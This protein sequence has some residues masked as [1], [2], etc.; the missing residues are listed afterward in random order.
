MA[1]GQINMLAL[2][3]TQRYDVRLTGFGL[4]IP[5]LRAGTVRPRRGD[6]LLQSAYSRE[7]QSAP[8]VLCDGLESRDR[9][10][11]PCVGRSRASARRR[12]R[13]PRA[14]L[15]SRSGRRGSRDAH[16]R[17]LTP[18]PP[19]PRSYDATTPGREYNFT[20]LHSRL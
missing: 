17:D 15:P 5:K 4:K 9:L 16:T 6:R 20:Q 2:T 12:A 19:T 3:V 13:K 8:S 11:E 14:G 7:S 10:D 1:R 18:W